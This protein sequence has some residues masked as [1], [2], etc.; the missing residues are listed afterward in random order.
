MS[1]TLMLDFD[2]LDLGDP[3]DQELLGR[4]LVDLASRYRRW[5]NRDWAE[6]AGSAYLSLV[7]R[8]PGRGVVRNSE[9]FLGSVVWSKA[10]NKSR[11]ER[12]HS[13]RERT[14]LL[15]RDFE[16]GRTEETALAATSDDNPADKIELK[17]RLGAILSHLSD[18]EQQV[19]RL[20]KY[21]GLTH[22]EIAEILE[23]PSEAASRQVLRRALNKAKRYL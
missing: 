10:C 22:A 1:G 11:S 5:F 13:E 9:S 3:R 17:R 12:V 15:E 19:V 2:R 18:Q 7:G 21:D 16:D 4:K 8:P 23:L 14:G 20:A 6:L